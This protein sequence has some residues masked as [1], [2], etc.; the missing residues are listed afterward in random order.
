MGSG[1]FLCSV[2]YR[3]KQKSIKINNFYRVWLLIYYQLTVFVISQYFTQIFQ[4][5]TLYLALNIILYFIIITKLNIL[6]KNTF[7]FLNWTD[8]Y[9]IFMI[10]EFTLQ[11]Y[12]YLNNKN[13][14]NN[15]YVWTFEGSP[16]LNKFSQY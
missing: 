4:N 13:I 8:N 7:F 10:W 6:I 14:I 2:I 5:L 3:Q 9:K 1:S 15:K 16:I 11:I 12:R